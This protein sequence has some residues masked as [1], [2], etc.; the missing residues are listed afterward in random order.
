[1]ILEKIGKI[2]KSL[3]KS[4]I[5]QIV[6]HVGLLELLKL[7]M[8]ELAFKMEVNPTLYFLLLIQLLAVDLCN[9]NLR[10]AMEVKLVVLGTGFILLE[11]SP[12]DKWEILLLVI[13][14]LCLNVSTMSQAPR[15]IVK[16]SNKLPLDANANALEINP[17]ITKL[18][19]TKLLREGIR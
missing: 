19:N 2:V 11:L 5:R 6:A 15:K 10:A 7:T 13:L 9:V 16:I 18:T 3:R 8:I 14:T 17:F 12:V 4:E 1:L